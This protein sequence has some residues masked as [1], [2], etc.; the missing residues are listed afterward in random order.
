MKA[1]LNSFGGIIP[2]YSQHQLPDNGATVAHNVKLRNGKIQAWRELLE[3]KYLGNNTISFYSYGCCHIGWPTIVYSA[4]VSPDWG[5]LYLAGRIAYPEVATIDKGTCAVTY[6][7]LGIYSPLSPLLANTT[8]ICERDTDGR[9]YV[10]TY[11]NSF[12]EE[13][14]PSPPSRLLNVQDGTPVSLTGIKLPPEEYDIVAVNIYR[15]ATAFR[16]EDPSNQSP[17][18]EWLYVATVDLP[19]TSYT[20]RKLLLELGNPLE[21]LYNNE[22][23]AKLTNLTSITGSIRLAGTVANRVYLSEVNEPYN[24]PAKYVLTMDSNIVHMVNVDDKLYVSTNTTPYIIDT[25]DCSEVSC[26]PVT[27]LGVPL[28]DI[29]CSHANAAIA[30]PHGMLYSSPLGLVLVSSNAQYHIITSDWF[31]AT[32][33]Q[34]LAPDTARLAY[35]EGFIFCITD[36]ISF[37]LNINGDVYNDLKGTELTT[38]SDKPIA[39]RV[40]NT[41]SLYMLID[42][43]LYIWDKANDYRPY[44]WVSTNISGGSHNANTPNGST[45]SPSSAK[46]KSKDTKF[47]I[48]TEDN[49]VNYSRVVVS[50]NP[51]RLPRIGRHLNYKIKLEGISPVE[52]VLLGNANNTLNY[53]E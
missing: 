45:W 17:A 52:Y 47:T 15:S 39:L 51:I 36:K 7:R 12:G 11:V 18:S 31:S 34:E 33:W 35:Y 26:T 19:S 27:D 38:I 50:D 46:I 22:P 6:R 23:P 29:S 28:P 1:V 41:G 24:W 10:Y 13:S 49:K 21:T 42:D 16:T 20:D 40:S 4:E 3:C 37:M 5:T 53:G 43:M 44:Q 2:R 8:E 48:Q 30:T 9:A 32:D 14:A 25:S